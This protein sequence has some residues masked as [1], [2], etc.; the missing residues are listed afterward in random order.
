MKKVIFI[1]AL[2][3]AM[4]I[5]AT[6]AFAQ[7][8]DIDR[9]QTFI[10]SILQVG[11]TLVGMI[12]AGFFVVGG[13]KYITSTGSPEAM[14]GAKKTII[15]SAFGLT[16]AIGALVLSNIISDLATTAFGK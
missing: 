15:Y 10:K 8:A 6:P 13:F 9:V 7:T 12:A 16:I 2:F 4:L 1:Q 5:T 3:L 14:E 11:V